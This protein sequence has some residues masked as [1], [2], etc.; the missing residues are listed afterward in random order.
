MK[1]FNTEFE[2]S[3]RILILLSKCKN[4][5]DEEKILYLDYFTIYSKNYGFNDDNA[6]GDGTFMINDLSSQKVL[7]KNSLKELVLQGF[8]KVQNTNQGFLYLINDDGLEICE[9]MSSDYS[10]EYKECATQIANKF[11]NKSIAEIKKCSIEKLN[12]TN[13][14]L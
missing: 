6:N 13:L 7:I 11:Y 1:I 14:Y 10:K 8:V 5:L 4:A 2:V 9:K 12:A 3:M